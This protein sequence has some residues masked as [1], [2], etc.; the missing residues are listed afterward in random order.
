MIERVVDYKIVGA[1]EFRALAEEV[2][3][4]IKEG[5]EPIGASYWGDTSSR[6]IRTARYHQTLI[7]REREGENK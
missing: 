2:C 4:L 3:E 7:K 5:W 6:T 1:Y